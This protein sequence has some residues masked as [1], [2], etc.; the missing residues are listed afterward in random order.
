MEE[1]KK[2]EAMDVELDEIESLDD[3]E[4]FMDTVAGTEDMTLDDDLDKEK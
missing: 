3:L 1:V 2:M 4:E